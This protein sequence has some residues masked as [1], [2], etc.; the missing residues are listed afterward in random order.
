M[1]SFVYALLLVSVPSPA[2][3][4]GNPLL[5]SKDTVYTSEASAAHG[6]VESVDGAYGFKG[7]S[8]P[9]ENCDS[10]GLPMLTRKLTAW[11]SL[12]A[13]AA[14]YFHHPAAQVK[15]YM[16]INAKTGKKV[17]FVLSITDPDTPTDTIVEKVID[18]VGTGQDQ[19]VELADCTFAAAKYYRYQLVCVSGNSDIDN[20]DRFTFESPSAERTYPAS[21]L[22]SPSVH[23][24][25]WRSTGAAPA[26]GYDWCYQEIMI[27]KSSDIVGTYAMALGVLSGYMGIQNNGTNADGKPAHDVLFSMWDDGSTD[28]DPD[29]PEYMRAGVVDCDS[30][31]TTNRFGNEGTGVQTYRRGD[32]WIPGRYV[33]FITNARREETTYTTTE[34]GKKVEHKQN[35]VLVSAWYN[36]QDGKGWQYLATVRKR[37]STELFSSWYS[38]LE[39]YNWPTG[40][41]SRKAY[42]RHGFAR[43]AKKSKWYNFNRVDFS[44]TD[45]GNAPGARND[46]G[47]GAT[48]NKDDCTFFMQTGGYTSTNCTENNVP[49]ATS[50]ECVDT[51]DYE[52]L[53]AR[54]LQAINNEKERVALADL[55]KTSKY[56][57]TGWK[58]ISF[59]SQET[60]G[61]G[62]NGRASQIIDGDAETYW[63]SQ[64]QG[65]QAKYPHYF[66]I[67]M[68]KVQSI[69]GF[70][71]TMSGGSNRYIKAYDIYVSDDNT[72]WQ[73]IYSDNDAPNQ[74]TFQ[75]RLDSA[76]DARYIKLVI[77]E[78]RATDG[79]FVR[80]NE[81][82]V[83]SGNVAL[84]VQQQPRVSNV[85]S[86]QLKVALKNHNID[87]TFPFD[88]EKQVALRLYS[89]NGICM[90]NS[91]FVAAKHTSIPM[92]QLPAGVYVVEAVWSEGAASAMIV[93]R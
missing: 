84:P 90:S 43:Y 47:Q 67:D 78:G 91:N 54:V 57:K 68:Q 28:E 81:F 63:H 7:I 75:V 20:I 45:G 48:E 27:P 60:N 6:Y 87:I 89:A 3:A 52:A 33:Q 65:T 80:L 16:T 56:D 41:A 24:G 83:M 69:G 10:T 92:P 8:I 64:W 93:T 11:T 55:F 30:L 37:N 19:K 73:K 34:G 13:R 79:C 31:T 53:N 71:L 42:Y 76:A 12:Q 72:N 32:C 85:V 70:E 38:F 23:L 39:N 74:A 1:K 59:S 29:L 35:N 26:N 36:A 58:V 40:E 5:C 25:S 82:D 9:G 50:T 61:E 51:I 14:Y 62:T 86:S 2:Y 18:V 22:S 4:L 15:S 21:Y 77:R 17:S 66:V 46:Y 44:H 49:L 88:G